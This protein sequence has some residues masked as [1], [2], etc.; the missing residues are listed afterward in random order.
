MAKLSICLELGIRQQIKVNN[1]KRHTSNISRWRNF[2]FQLPNWKSADLQ[3]L[4]IIFIKAIVY[5]CELGLGHL[6][7]TCGFERTQSLSV[8][9]KLQKSWTQ[10]RNSVVS[11]CWR[12]CCCL[13][14]TVTLIHWKLGEKGTNKKTKQETKC[15]SFYLGTNLKDTFIV[16]FSMWLF[17]FVML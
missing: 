10:I 2:V 7:W 14:D 8:D 17:L 13:V 15:V 5:A 11:R 16:I 1:A 4:G 12:I 6:L 3:L 9:I